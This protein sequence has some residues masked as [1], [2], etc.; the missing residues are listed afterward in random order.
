MPYT[1]PA[2][3]IYFTL[4]QVLDFKSIQGTDRFADATDET[5]RAILT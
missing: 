5:T 4:S 3:D 1:S 2:Q